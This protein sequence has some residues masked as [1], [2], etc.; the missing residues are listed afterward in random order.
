M[1]GALALAKGPK[2]SLLTG[3]D[4]QDVL[5]TFN[6]SASSSHIDDYINK[7]KD[8]LVEISREVV[9]LMNEFKK[10]FG[11]PYLSTPSR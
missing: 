11:A 1:N 7:Y 8:E 5:L 4:L 9:V 3:T 6:F 2:I 10:R